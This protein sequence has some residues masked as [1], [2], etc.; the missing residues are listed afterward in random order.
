MSKGLE[1]LEELRKFMSGD[2]Y[3]ATYNRLD[4][5]ETELKRIPELEKEI[6]DTHKAYSMAI[7]KHIEDENEY[8]KWVQEGGYD[9]KKLKAFEIIKEK[10]VNVWCL[11]NVGLERYNNEFIYRKERKL[12]AKEYDLL[13]EVLL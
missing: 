8:I 4:I 1:A 3:C 9:Q 13:K 5:I 2:L 6:E 7:E 10:R 11:L 12:T